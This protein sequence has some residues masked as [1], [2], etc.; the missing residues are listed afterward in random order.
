ML[1][2]G[3]LGCLVASLAA[4]TNLQ[5]ETGAE[6]GRP[7]QWRV[8]TLALHQ[9]VALK[10]TTAS[11]LRHNGRFLAKSLHKVERGDHPAPS[12][13]PLPRSTECTPLLHYAPAPKCPAVI[14]TTPLASRTVLPTRPARPLPTSNSTARPP[15]G[16]ELFLEGVV[17]GLTCF[18]PEDVAS[19]MRSFGEDWQSVS[20]L[21]KSAGRL[22]RAPG[23]P[24]Q[25]LD[26]LLCAAGSLL[27]AAGLWYLWSSQAPMARGLPTEAAAQPGQRLIVQPAA[28]APVDLGAL[29]G[30]PDPA[31]PMHAPRDPAPPMNAPAEN[32]E[33]GAPPLPA[34]PVAPNGDAFNP[35]AP[36]AV[37]PTAEPGAVV[38]QDGA[39]GVDGAERVAAGE[40]LGAGLGGK[41]EGNSERGAAA[42][43]EDNQRE[44]VGVL[45][46][47]LVA[48]DIEGDEEEVEVEEEEASKDGVVGVLAGQLEPEAAFNGDVTATNREEKEPPEQLSRQR[49]I[50]LGGFG[51]AGMPTLPSDIFAPGSSEI[52]HRTLP[53]Y[54]LAA[55]PEPLAGRHSPT[56]P[57]PAQVTARAERTNSARQPALPMDLPF[58]HHEP[59]LVTPPRAQRVGL[60]SDLQSSPSSSPRSPSS[61]RRRTLPPA[62]SAIPSPSSPRF[63]ALLPTP[64][65]PPPSPPMTMAEFGD[66]PAPPNGPTP[67]ASRHGLWVRKMALSSPAAPGPTTPRVAGVLGA[68]VERGMQAVERR[69]VEEASSTR[70][71]LKT[72]YELKTPQTRTA[73]DADAQRYAGGRPSDA[74]LGI[75]C[76]LPR[77]VQPFARSNGV[78][79]GAGAGGQWLTELGGLPETEEEEEN[80]SVVVAGEGKGKARMSGE[81]RGGSFL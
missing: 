50:S 49:A 12:P 26:Y 68:A 73:I 8:T 25:S 44:L 17:V 56:T 13:S 72:V 58:A 7:G 74:E 34:A 28:P 53:M 11:Y 23:R 51:M 15:E 31:G 54:T 35:A 42:R 66:V 5:R 4:L 14:P 18:L 2:L 22:L 80:I 29:V 1:L 69:E 6:I 71:T 76:A 79:A 16:Y 3:P 59:S 46:A 24:L 61:D 10:S 27:I 36:F 77:L 21:W 60:V 70:S 65:P 41:G 20:R 47:E 63:L 37:A 38:A 40:R 43:G 78:G 81:A 67:R 30:L 75:L 55:A 33:P 62:S 32:D 48:A 52:A 19:D 64:A 9:I 57:C 39:E 45:V